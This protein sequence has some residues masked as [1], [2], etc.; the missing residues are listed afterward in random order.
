[1]PRRAALVPHLLAVLVLATVT[2]VWAGRLTGT[3]T[4]RERV[5][6]PPDAVFEAVLL[7]VARADAPA[8]VLGRATIDPAGQPPFRFVIAYDD[9]AVPPGGRFAVRATVKHQGRLLFTTDRSYPVLPATNAPLS[10]LLV[11]AGAGRPPALRGGSDPG[12]IDLPASFEGELPAAGGGSA[13]WHL[14]LL[15]MGRY[16]MR[17]FYKDKPE[18][19]RSDDIGRW[20]RDPKTGRLELRGGRDAPVAF[21]LEDGGRTLREAGG[22]GIPGGSGPG[23][24]LTRRP[25]PALIEPRLALSGMFTY[26][27]DAAVITLCADG[28][29][30]PVAMEADYKALETAYLKE[31]PPPGQPLL[32]S[33]DGLIASRPSMESSQ[34]PRPTLVVERF[35]NIWPRET[36]G[37]P[38]VDSPLRGTY[39][40]LVRLSDAPVRAADKQRE[41]YLIFA[42]GERRVSG[43]GGCN[44]MTG[45]FEV[46]GDK[47]R[48]RGMAGTMRACPTGMEQEQRFRQAMTTVE[49]YRIRGSHLEL[50]DT[51]GA[52]VA[53]FEAVALR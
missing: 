27:A 50:L 6:L 22:A 45:D 28:G 48:V 41:P 17:T 47:L 39:W 19:N 5:A 2:P 30:L 25:Q 32:V 16:Q 34:P 3:A 49:R 51:A 35:V 7:D 43:S 12:G 29:R 42:N 46:D 44:R 9:A 10:I 15:P 53:R 8:A 24:L 31:R 23:G 37:N 33:V 1:M 26:M 11:S 20:R 18:P 21:I 52:V 36:C 14:D 13:L 4:Y 40:K 38:L